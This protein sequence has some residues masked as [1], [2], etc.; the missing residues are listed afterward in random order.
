MHPNAELLGRLFNGL[1]HHDHAA[2]ARCYRSDAT[3]SDI[4]FDLHGGQQIHA[5]WNM[6]CE[7]DIRATFHVVHADDDAGRVQLC[8]DYTFSSTGRKVHNLIDSHFRFAD[9]LIVKHHDSCDP[10]LW[11]KMA[12]GGLSGFLAGRFRFLRASK[13]REMLE[14]FVAKNP[15]YRSTPPSTC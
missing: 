4:A 6:I 15:Q 13:A 12:L 14:T 9:G 2:M 11:A 5:M 1:D 10:H 7:T 8:D 3:F